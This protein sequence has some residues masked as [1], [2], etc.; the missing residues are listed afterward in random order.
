MQLWN[1]S[2]AWL[3]PSG[4]YQINYK[5]ILA[6][7]KSSP[8]PFPSQLCAGNVLYYSSIP[9]DVPASAYTWTNANSAIT[10]ADQR[11]WKEYIDYVI[12]VWRDPEGDVVHP[13][14]PACSYGPDFTAGSGRT[15]MMSGPDSSY[16]PGYPAFVAPSDNP[17]RP[18][19]RLWFGPMTMVQFISDTGIMPGTVHDISLVAAKLGVAGALQDIQINHPNDLV[20]MV[21]FSRPPYS[22]EPDEVGRFGQ[23]QVSLSMDYTKLINGLW[24]PPNSSTSDVRPWDPNGLQTPS[25]H[26]DYDANT[27]SDYAFMLAYNQFS[28]NS[29]LA[30]AGMGGLGAQRAQK[31]VIF[32]TDGMANQ[33][34]SHPFTNSGAYKSYYS[35]GNMGSCNSSSADPATA[36]QNVATNI[37]ALD[38]ASAPGFAQPQ[39]PVQIHCIAFG[40]VFEPTASGSE[41]SNAVSFLQCSPRLAVPRSPRR[42]VIPITAINGASAH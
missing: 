7:I 33:A 31:I 15:P 42:Q 20:S 11:F 6:W 2:G 25:A 23:P 39:R 3:D 41:Q 32:E 27:G 28:S 35:I 13:G 40:A 5:A 34:S 12:G 22:G 8:C 18:R 9:T 30:A 19:H 29:S 10:D 17:K 38:T 26:G 21:L 37:C 36:A 1:S 4:K 24:Y 14:S 16:K